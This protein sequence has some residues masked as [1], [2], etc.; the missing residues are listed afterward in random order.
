M[1][2]C[3][4]GPF[5]QFWPIGQPSLN[6]WVQR[7]EPIGRVQRRIEAAP[8]SPP[9]GQCEVHCDRPGPP[10]WPG[11]AGGYRGHSQGGSRSR[12]RY[13][14]R[15]SR[16]RSSV[17]RRSWK[18]ESKKEQECGIQVL[19]EAKQTVS[20]PDKFS[21][22]QFLAPPKKVATESCVWI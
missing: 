8:L 16:S 2:F 12:S 9:G 19:Q 13:R 18:Q 21:A 6:P 17:T 22:T 4:E 1:I 10:L 11:G 15:R 3:V 14:S 5:T 7:R 20:D